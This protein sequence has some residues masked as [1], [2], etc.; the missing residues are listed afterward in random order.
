[1]QER[2]AHS[3]PWV[4]ALDPKSTA[5]LYFRMAAALEMVPNQVTYP[6][7]GET[8]PMQG[9][10]QVASCT[11]PGIYY[12]VHLEHGCTCP[13]YSTKAP[14]GWCKHR[15]AVWLY[16]DHMEAYGLSL[17]GQKESAQAT[18]KAA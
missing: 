2:F 12:V 17:L 18:S 11:H 13:D 6:A 14:F 1:M 5:G 15:L 9:Y 16:L 7:I 8:G 4:H 10:F 3:H